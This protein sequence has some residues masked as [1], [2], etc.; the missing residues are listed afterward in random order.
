[1][2]DQDERM[3]ARRDAGAIDLVVVRGWLANVGS[4]IVNL[5]HEYMREPNRSVG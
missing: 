4:D 1:M 2:P 3:D 5:I